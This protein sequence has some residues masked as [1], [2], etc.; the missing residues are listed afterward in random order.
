MKRR[1]ILRGRR[2]ALLCII[3]VGCVPLATRVP[4]AA[5]V[6]R[7]QPPSAERARS[8]RPNIIFIMADD[9]GVGHLGCYGQTR[10]RTP[11][12]DRLAQQGLR[13]AQA[14]AGCTVCAPS[15]STLMTGLHMG[16]TPVR[17]NPGGIPLRASDITV[18]EVLKKAGYA[19]GIFGKWGLGDARTTGVPEKHGFDESFGYLHQVHAHFYYPDYL[20]KNG[21][22]FILQENSGGKRGRYS[23]DLIVSEALDFVRAHRDRPFFLYLAPTIPHLEL[24]VPEDSLDEYRGRFPE[25]PFHDPRGHYADQAT[26]HAAIA[27]M[28]TRLD[29]GVGQLMSLLEELNLDKNTIVF[30]TSDNGAQNGYATDPDFFKATGLFRGYKQDFYEGGIRVP[31]I[32]R[33]PGRVRPGRMTDQIWAHWD[34]MP[35]AAEVAGTRAPSNVDGISLLPTILDKQQKQH[36]FYYWEFGDAAKLAQAVRAGDWKGVRTRPG[37]ALELYDL[38]ADPGEKRN[39]A[40]DHPDVA[41]RI[42]K[43]LRTARV[44]PP[45]QIEPPKEPGKS[46]Q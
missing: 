8:A 3:A 24:L 4:I 1:S 39:V 36:S 23:H 15:R 19:T 29:R 44:D 26:P 42:E 5:T 38:K 7:Q 43:I 13:F 41:A 35:T 20:W 10:I 22:K 37:V 16:H 30:F 28:I 18:A 45:P 11:N 6:G 27:G 21:A 25:T 31:M 12:I 46:Y 17:L 32:I 40:A 14:Y 33:W 9:L 34:F 2:A